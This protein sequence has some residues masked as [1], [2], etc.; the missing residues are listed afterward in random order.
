[1]ISKEFLLQLKIGWIDIELLI[2]VGLTDELLLIFGLI[3]T[4]GGLFIRFSLLLM[5][6]ILIELLFA[7]LF[8]SVIVILGMLII[9]L[10]FTK[11]YLF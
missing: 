6:I 8:L 11:A 4:S 7:K 10:L 1:M 5:W 9:V 3:K 2:R